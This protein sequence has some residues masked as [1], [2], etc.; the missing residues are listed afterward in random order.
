MGKNG[1]EEVVGKARFLG[2]M[3]GRECSENKQSLRGTNKK[4]NSG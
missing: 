2:G 3:E 1:R 4:G